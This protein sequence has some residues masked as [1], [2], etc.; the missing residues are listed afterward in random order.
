MRCAL[1]TK[2]LQNWEDLCSNVQWYF[3][4][5]EICK[6]F[7]TEIS[8][9]QSIWYYMWREILP[10]DRLGRKLWN[11]CWLQDFIKTFSSHLHYPILCHL[12]C[13]IISSYAVIFMWAWHWKKKKKITIQRLLF[14]QGFNTKK[15]ASR[16][17]YLLAPT[18]TD[19]TVIAVFS[20]LKT[21]NK[22]K[23]LS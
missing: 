3:I 7:L 13:Q 22:L 11:E 21:T 23:F 10:T 2:K 5:K 6:A 14:T 16:C 1:L 15:N 9:T 20:S 4:Q 17:N 8:E 18:T 19:H 12:G